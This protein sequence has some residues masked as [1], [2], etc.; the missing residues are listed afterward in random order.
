M[1]EQE[2]ELERRVD[3]GHSI[4]LI[5]SHVDH[6]VMLIM[7]VVG[8]AYSVLWTLLAMSCLSLI[9]FINTTTITIILRRVTPLTL[10]PYRFSLLRK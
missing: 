1:E 4:M 5:M 6:S 3:V 10:F 2:L 9:A 8:H 7:D